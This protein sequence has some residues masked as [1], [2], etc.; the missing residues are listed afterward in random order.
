M[1]LS[2]SIGYQTLTKDSPGGYHERE[3]SSS[4]DRHLKKL[5]RGLSI[6]QGVGKLSMVGRFTDQCKNRPSSVSLTYTNSDKRNA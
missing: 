3:R 2:M 6:L 4:S 1:P 5:G